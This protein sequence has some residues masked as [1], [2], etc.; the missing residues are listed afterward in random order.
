MEALCLLQLFLL[1]RSLLLAALAQ[2]LHLQII[3][4]LA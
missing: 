3:T 1:A 2:L 4:M